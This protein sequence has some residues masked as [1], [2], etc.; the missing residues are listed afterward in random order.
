MKYILGLLL[1]CLSFQLA[2]QNVLYSEFQKID[3]RNADYSIVGKVS[4]LVY[5][6]RATG[7]EHFL[8]AWDDSMQLRAT[9]ILDFMPA[10][11][12]NPTFVAYPD[13]MIVLFQSNEGGRIAQQ[14]ALLDGAG[15]LQ[16][17]VLKVDEAKASFFGSRGDYFS[18]AVADNKRRMAIYDASVKGAHLHLR[19]T[20][21]DDSL[22]RL[23][24]AE[25]DYS[26]E[27]NL[28]LLPAILDNEGDFFQPVV[29]ALGSKDYA[30]GVWLL[31]LPAGENRLKVAELPLAGKYAAGLYLRADNISRCIYAAGFFSDKKAGNFDGVLMAQFSLDS[32]RFVQARRLPFDAALRAAAGAR[33][34]QRAFNDF[35]TRQLVVRNDGGFVLIAE[36]YYMSVRSGLSPY[37]YYTSAYAPFMGAQNVREYHYGDV[38]ALCYDG[39][40]NPLWHAFVR[41]DQYSQEDA[42]AFSSYAFVNTG[43]ALGFLFNDFDSRNSRITLG[44][45]ES[46]G[47]VE[48]QPL[49]V[50][51]IR[52]DWQ[53]RAGKQVASRTLIVP[54]LSRRQLSFAKVVF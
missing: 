4:G 29:T 39:S 30:D 9:V 43:G 53:P 21:L 5:T 8:D 7:G 47:R 14:A 42:G 41:K 46:D 23:H 24:R 27:N 34:S 51:L 49:N 18:V 35:L 38:M 10:K 32:N 2:A 13:K 11:V 31:R 16:G 19:C 1:S 48:M 45:I 40:G 15:R 28:S 26:A 12:F 50:G 54:C 22:H 52:A 20:I 25:T 36:D 3:F 37:G 33:K 17:K 44:T 6:Y